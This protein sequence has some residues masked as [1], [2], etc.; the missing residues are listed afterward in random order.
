MLI[1]GGSH[2]YVASSEQG[3]SGCEPVQ[4]QGSTQSAKPGRDVSEFQSSLSRP[5]TLYVMSHAAV[6]LTLLCFP[7]QSPLIHGERS[8]SVMQMRLDVLSALYEQSHSVYT[9]ACVQQFLAVRQVCLHL[10]PA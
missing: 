5:G 9:A 10:E 1:V 2:A 4:R 7:R 6:C 3:P 8:V